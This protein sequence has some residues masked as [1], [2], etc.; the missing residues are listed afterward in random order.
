MPQSRTEQRIEALQLQN[1]AL[2]ATV[3]DLRDLVGVVAESVRVIAQAVG[4]PGEESLENEG[5]PADP[6]PLEPPAP[7]EVAEGE[8]P[9]LD[10]GD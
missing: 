5:S 2:K 3:A 7:E 4:I 6:P 1:E 8:T 10:L 9:P